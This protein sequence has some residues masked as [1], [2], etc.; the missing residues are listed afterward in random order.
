MN[1]LEF[2]DTNVLLYAYDISN[3]DKQRVARD[4]VTRAL[5]GQ[6]IIS[7]QVLSELAS[8]MLHKVSPHVSA[9]NVT[10]ILDALTPI[11]TITSDSEIVRRAVAAHLEY[12]LHFYDGMIIAAAERAGCETIWSE[13]LNAGQKYFGIAVL[14]PFR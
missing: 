8:A 14:N 6:F 12:G 10:A 5:A 4:L 1:G 11:R 7:I 2:L 3:P 13:D 9:S